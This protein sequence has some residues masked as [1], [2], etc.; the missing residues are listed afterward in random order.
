M[1]SDDQ[2]MPYQ[3]AKTTSKRLII[4]LSLERL[5]K[6]LEWGGLL[7]ILNFLAPKPKLANIWGARG[8]GGALTFAIF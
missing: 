6:D 1:S 7:R 4:A 3:V 2:K 8:S 5:L